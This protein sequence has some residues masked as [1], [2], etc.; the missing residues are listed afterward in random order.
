[1][2]ENN[3]KYY[4]CPVCFSIYSLDKPQEDDIMYCEHCD[5]VEVL[6]F[7]EF[8]YY[9]S[10]SGLKELKEEFQRSKHLEPDLKDFIVKNIDE[11]ITLIEE[12]K[13]EL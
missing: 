12:I 11:V 7:S 1:M 9:S 10:A 4:I 5:G 13:G 8:L 3:K 6:E 2:P